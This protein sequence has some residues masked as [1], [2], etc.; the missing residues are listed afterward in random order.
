M[1][2]RNLLLLIIIVAAFARPVPLFSQAIFIGYSDVFAIGNQQYEYPSIIGYSGV[3]EMNTRGQYFTGYSGLFILNTIGGIIHGQITDNQTGLP[4]QNATVQTMGYISPPSNQQGYY[5]IN[6]PFGYGYQVSAVVPFYETSVVSGINVPPANAIMELNFELVPGAFFPGLTT[7]VPNPNP[8]ISTVQQGGTLHRYYKVAN[9]PGAKPWPPIPVKVTGPGFTRTYHSNGDGIVDVFIHSYEIGFGQPEMQTQFSITELNN[10]LI[11]EPINFIGKVI[12]Q[13][14]SK[15]WDSKTVTKLGISHL[16]IEVEGGFTS[17][18]D[19]IG[20]SIPQTFS[21]TRQLRAGGGV[22]A[23]VGAGLSVQ[24]GN[25]TRGGHAQAGVGAVISGI[26]EDNYVFPHINYSNWDAV[27]QYILIADGSFGKLDNTM[28]RFLTVCQNAFTSQSTLDNAYIGD[29]KAIDIKG[30]A[31]ASAQMGFNLTPKID[32]SGSGNIGLTGRRVFDIQRDHVNNLNIWGMEVNG[33]ITGG[34]GGGIKFNLPPT[35]LFL[36]NMPDLYT[37]YNQEERVGF[38]FEIV[39]EPW[40]GAIQEYRLTLMRRSSTNNVGFEKES[41]YVFTGSDLITIIQTINI[42]VQNLAGAFQHNSTITVSNTLFQTLCHQI[43]NQVSVLQNN[44][45]DIA[46]DYFVLKRDFTNISSVPINI[47]VGLEKLLKLSVEFGAETGFEEGRYRIIEKGKWINGHHFPNETFSG[48]IPPVNIS[49]QNKM[50]QITDEVP[51]LIRSL[52]GGINLITRLFKQDSI[53]Y[54]GDNGSFAIIPEISF[55]VGIDSLSVTSWSWYGD[56]PSKKLGDMRSDEQLLFGKNRQRA[57]NSFGM[58]YGIGGFYQFEPLDSLFNEP[59]QITINYSDDEIQDFD[60]L[61]LGMYFEDKSNK[62]WIYL[63]GEV[64]TVNKMVTAQ[65]NKLALFTLAPALPYGSFGLNAM[66]ESIYADSISVTTIL[67]DTIFNNNGTLASNGQLFTVNTT[68]GTIITQDV[69]TTLQGIQLPVEN[70]KIEFLVRSNHIGGEALVSARSV[71]GSAYAETQVLFYDTIPPLHPIIL[72]ITSGDQS[73]EILWSDNEED[74]LAGYIIHYDTDTLPPYNGIHT[75]FGNPSPIIVGLEN[76]RN[77]IGLFND[78]TYFFAVSA[79]D[80]SGNESQ[81]SPFVSA[82]PRCISTVLPLSG[83]ITSDADTCF[84]ATQT[85][86]A[87]DIVV[88][89]GAVVVLVAG[90]SIK[91]E[92]LVQIISGSHFSAYIDSTGNYCQQ[93]ESIIS[94]PE[95]DVLLEPVY[96]EKSPDYPLFRVYPN[97]TTGV[98]KLMIAETERLSNIHV[99]VFGMMGEQ[100]LST[101]LYGRNHHEFNLS[102]YPRGV[103]L[104][105]VVSG[106]KTSSAKIIRQ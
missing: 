20:G 54:I 102:A 63:G 85:I 15:Y 48:S 4:I 16:A 22:T 69:D 82:K 49:F 101:E 8:A 10:Q 24:M 77:V 92:P 103:Y 52:I 96:A 41:C 99:T 3:F 106:D 44:N 105:R 57:E 83:L 67:S 73:V 40:L 9:L 59:V 46:V 74:D 90:E 1:K 91:L 33:Q 89:I 30:D 43:F 28:I 11:A 88:E 36:A 6:V 66:P 100:I 27:A 87:S 32:I 13:E 93:P 35:S 42:A 98:I 23:G 95:Q 12:N 31:S 79:Y 65:V 47:F 72:N 58:R 68:L 75:V 21:V 7:I 17:S 26:T 76:I 34:A 53:Y 60:E 86:I 80:I 78:T 97:P 25:I 18:L 61:T 104:I 39:R 5:S 62:K 19:V 14:Y 37:V 38:R 71:N 50:Q 51:L 81:L 70:H 64:D 29:R 45:L 2:P 56:S 55:P 84:S 94:I